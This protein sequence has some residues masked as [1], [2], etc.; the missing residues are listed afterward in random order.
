MR[1]FTAAPHTWVGPRGSSK[2]SRTVRLKRFSRA[3]GKISLPLDLRTRPRSTETNTRQSNICGRYHSSTAIDDQA[4]Q[5]AIP[6]QA[7]GVHFGAVH[8]RPVNA[9]LPSD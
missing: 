7:G 1:S 5:Y 6:R 4:K 8:P 9:I 3:N 2:S